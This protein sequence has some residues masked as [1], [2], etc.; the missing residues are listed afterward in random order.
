MRS[1]R[2]TAGFSLI[3]LMIVVVILGVFIG[4][5]APALLTNTSSSKLRG[6]AENLAAQIQLARQKAVSIGVP[7]PFHIAIDSLGF[8]YHIHVPGSRIVGGALPEGIGYAAGTMS[9]F[10]LTTD[11]RVSSAAIIVLLDRRG[12]R[13]TVSVQK[14]GLI[15]VQ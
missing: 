1:V 12:V 13:D 9:G 8:D 2:R 5:A 3:E 6:A 11:G 7:Q 15:L 10:T 4:F 14:S